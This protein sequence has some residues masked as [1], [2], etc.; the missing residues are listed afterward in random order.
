[1]TRGGILTIDRSVSSRLISHG[2]AQ[3]QWYVRYSPI[4][5]SFD[6]RTALLITLCDQAA[7]YMLPMGRSGRIKPAIILDRLFVAMPFP[8]LEYSKVLCSTVSHNCA[9]SREKNFLTNGEMKMPNS[10][11]MM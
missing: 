4:F 2:V 6:K 5:K 11:E 3:G 10:S 8:N 7:K 9:V 1:M